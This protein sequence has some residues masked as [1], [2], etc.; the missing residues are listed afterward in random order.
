[1]M[2]SIILILCTVF[3][4]SVIAQKSLKFDSPDREYEKGLE[5]YK[6][7]KFGL[8]RI[9]FSNYVSAQQDAFSSRV[10]EAAY[11][12]R[13]CAQKLNNEDVLFLWEEYVKS[14]PYSNRLP[15]AYMNVGDYFKNKGKHRQA[16]RWFE[17]VRPKGLDKDTRIDYYFSYGY[18]LF[19]NEEYDRAL[20]MFNQIKD[21]DHEYYSSV[22]YFYSHIHYVK[23]NYQT[24]LDGFIELEDD[25]GFK[26]VVPFYIAQIYYLQEDYDNAIKYALPLS[27]EGS[28][29][30]QED[31]NRII[32]DSYYGKKDYSGSI[33][34]YEKAIEVAAEPRREDYYHLGFANYF[35]G[36]YKKATEVLSQVTSSEDVMSQNA[37]YH[38][39]D[40]YL[41]LGDNKR[42]RVAF[43]AASKYSF[44]QVIQEDALFN[45]IKLNYELAYSPFNEIINSFLKYIELF[46]ESDKI[47]QAYDYLG[48]AFLT[49]KNYREALA[50]MEKIRAKSPGVYKAMQRVAYYRGLELFT[51]LQFNQAIE[52]F[53]YSLKYGEYDKK[54]KVGAY[55][56]RGESF[57]RLRNFEKAIGDYREFIFMPGSY[58]MEEFAIAHYNIGYSYFKKKSYADS[59]SWFR[60]FIKLAKQDDQMLYGDALNRIGDCYYV[61][62][63]FTSAISYYEQAAEIPEASADYAMFQKAFCL[64]LRK[65]YSSKIDVLKTLSNRYPKSPYVDDALYEMGRSYVAI[66]DLQ[67]AIYYYKTVKEKYPKGSYAKKAMLQLGL[68]YYNNNEN[69]NSMTFYKRVINEFPGTQEAEDALLGVRNIYLDQNDLD[70]YV[71]YTE[72]LGGFA[73]MDVREQDS[74][75]FVA[76]ERFYMKNDCQHAIRHFESYI[77][78]YPDGKYILNAHFYKADCQYRTGDLRDALTS[79]KYVANRER[80]LFT[81][82]SLI[83]QGEILFMNKTYQEAFGVFER[84]ER[85]AEIGANRLEAKIGQMRCLSQIPDLAGTITVANKVLMAPK[86]G[87]EIKREAIFNLANS[88]K[89]LGDVEKAMSEY[90]KLAGNTKSIEGAE[91]KYRVAQLQYDQKNVE[92]AEKEIFD[93]IDKGTSHQYWLARSFILLSEIYHD[94]G[95][96]FQAIQYLQSIKEN[97]KGDDDISQRVDKY[98]SEWEKKV[99]MPA[100]SD[101]LGIN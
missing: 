60:K 24:A 49:T 98:L 47:D 63:D 48:Q 58:Q 95:E 72:Q 20:S 25:K 57:Y 43:E 31:M 100:S 64:G 35:I 96:N 75:S 34:Y 92:V 68:V 39:G 42:A 97:Y 1:M 14:Y 10:A 89:A 88:Y 80:S 46:P 69:Q 82:E 52:F 77:N 8:A 30:R 76:A 84:L 79:Y 90:G 86:I 71:L 27:E 3:L 15:Y 94:R 70:G 33:P 6:L 41:K 38:L 45:Y 9:H 83:R 73:K 37:Y 22:K 50:S 18:S 32:A 21:A 19:S 59:K 2:R 87:D 91:A 11:L 17:K 40:C 26:K 44:D 7:E 12:E 16:T 54:L 99:A 53:D 56:W 13:V 66:N 81:E 78:T 28:K 36:K 65:D 5:L 61:E 55:Y 85:E 23:G 51:D 4:Q 62:R 74:L 67:Q 93:Y 101:T 29:N